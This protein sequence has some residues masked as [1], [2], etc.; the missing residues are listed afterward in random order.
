VTKERVR[1][2]AW[3]EGCCAVEAHALTTRMHAWLGNWERHGCWLL[4]ISAFT[5]Q[6]VTPG[7][8][9]VA[10]GV[11]SSVLCRV[12]LAGLRQ[13]EQVLTISSH[14]VCWF[15]DLNVEKQ[16]CSVYAR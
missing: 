6:H 8:D 13:P 10:T 15:Q 9:R 1:S 2:Y 4:T 7:N 5:G 3:S 12:R 16:W 14:I 11:N